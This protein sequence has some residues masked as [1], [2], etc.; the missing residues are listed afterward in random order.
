[1]QVPLIM[2]CEVNI[3]VNR[4][5]D[6]VKEVLCPWQYKAN[7][8]FFHTVAPVL[9]SSL[10]DG[11]DLRR[12]RSIAPGCHTAITSSGSLVIQHST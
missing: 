12:K 10:P 1:M 5:S 2:Y 8:C 4:T 7:K 3:A 9:K 11:F 6:L